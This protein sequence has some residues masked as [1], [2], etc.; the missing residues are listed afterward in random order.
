MQLSGVLGGEKDSATRFL[1]PIV[2]AICLSSVFLLFEFSA[3]VKVL[4]DAKSSYLIRLLQESSQF[5][6]RAQAAIS[7]GRVEK[8]PA[9]IKALI[10]ALHDQ[11]SAVRAASASS[12]ERLGDP[13]A[14]SELEKCRNDPEAAVKSAVDRAITTL[15]KALALSKP[16]VFPAGKPAKTGTATPRFYVGV[17]LPGTKSD[18]I[19]KELLLH[20]QKFI[21]EQVGALDGVLVAPGNEN[22]SQVKTVLVQQK[23][24]GFYLDSSVVQVEKQPGGGLRVVVSVIVGTYPGR[25]MRSILQGAATVTGNGLGTEVQAV[26][27]AFRGALKRLPQALEVAKN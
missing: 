27:G 26:E 15:Q 4:A 16:G 20:A 14:L 6:V 7:L 3:P 11:H 21:E 12:L 5:R 13:S 1:R 9:V 18:A 19:G 10:V 22:P 24:A 8:E 23:L 17:G 2:A 25:D